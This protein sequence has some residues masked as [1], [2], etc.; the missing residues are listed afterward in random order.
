LADYKAINPRLG[1]D[2]NSIHGG[3]RSGVHGLYMGVT[4]T[5]D[6][7]KAQFDG[8]DGNPDTMDVGD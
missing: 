1:M 2:H 6:L 8:L 5:L 7:Q 4:E 3:G